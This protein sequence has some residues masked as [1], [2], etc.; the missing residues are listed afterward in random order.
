M[1]K[2]PSSIVRRNF[3]R[4]M[5]IAGATLSFAKPS[6][7][8]NHD[9]LNVAIIGVGAQG[10][11]LLNNCMKTSTIRVKAI[12]DIWEKYNLNRASRILAGYQQEHTT[13]LDYR[14]M[15]DQEK[16][17]DAVLIATP[18]SFHAEQTIAC[19]QAGLPVYCE[20]MMANTI[21]DAKAICKAAKESGKPLQIGFQRRSNPFYHFAYDHIINETRM[22]GKVTAINAQWNQPVQT[23][24]GWP[25]R[26]PMDEETLQQYGFDS[27]QQFRN[28]MWYP[29]F[30][31]GPLGELGAH[32]IDAINWFMDGPPKS[33]TASGKTA[34]YDEKTHKCYDTVMAILNYQTPK[35]DV[36]A[37]Y[38]TINNNSNFGYY[39]NFMGDEGTLYVSEAVNRVRVYREPTAPDWEKWVKL[40]LLKKIEDEEPQEEKKDEEEALLD[41]QESIIPPEYEL[42]VEIK[43]SVFKPHLNNFFQAVRGDEDLLC[44]PELA[45]QSTVTLLKIWEAAETA[46]TIELTPED[47][48]I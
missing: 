44:P 17:L 36:Q 15:L 6:S 12:C 25:R 34:Y 42:P 28:W 13:Y 11:L 27:M 3:L 24:R 9:A 8:Q 10:Q 31:R 40:G 41:V 26:A 48:Q 32:Q 43:E 14:E 33:I 19:L 39:E 7:S 23:E 21:E 47:F 29:Q 4:S 38:Q 30:G 16:E 20:S 35:G 2:Q 18:D 5:A 45:Y 37:L 1:N 22:L 46:K